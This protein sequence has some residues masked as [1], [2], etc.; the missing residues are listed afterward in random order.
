MTLATLKGM[1][2]KLPAD[3]FQRIHRSYIVSVH[4]VKSIHNRKVKLASSAELPVS[5]SYADFIKTWRGN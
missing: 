1:L 5:D 2:E 4:K 3:K